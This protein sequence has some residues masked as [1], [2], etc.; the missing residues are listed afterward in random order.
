MF[1]FV[2]N[3]YL[4]LK[5]FH[6]I[7]FICWMA[8][9]LYLPRLFVYHTRSQYNSE[10]YNVFLVMESKLI[11]YIMTPSMLI[12]IVF[13]SLLLI[14]QDMKELWLHVKLT[15]VIIMV[16]I[17]VMNIQWYQGFSSGNNMKSERFFRIMNEV[18]AVLMIIIVFA[19]ILK[20]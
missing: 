8:A 12:T 13:G 1:D 6:V 14:I 9:L 10:T 17:H 2:V 16:V 20:F 11:R 19:A 18:P 5:A 3:N 4:I 15:A 7:A